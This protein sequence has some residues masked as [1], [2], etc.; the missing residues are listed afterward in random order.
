MTERR[1]A[2]SEPAP[3]VVGAA[4]DAER[5]PGAQPSARPG[6]ASAALPLRVAYV[7]MLFPAGSETFATTDVRVLRGA[8]VE[9]AVHS[10]RTADPDSERMLTQR[11]L[12]G[13][14]VTH[15]GVRASL[16]GVAALLARPRSALA[17]LGWLVRA[18]AR[19]PTHLARA[20]LVTPRAFGILADLQRA[21]PDVVHLFWGHYPALV[22][23]L[24]QRTMP[25]TVV[26]V[27]LGAH[28][29]RIGFGGSGPVACAAD[30]V[31]THVRANVPVLARL[32]VPAEEVQVAYRGVDVRRLREIAGVQRKLPQR[33]VT[34]GRLTPEKGVAEVLQAFALVHAQRPDASLVVLGDGPER[35]AL[36]RMAGDL[37]VAPAVR[38]L[39]H[40]DQDAVFTEM[41]KAGVFLFLSAVESLPNVV[42]EAMACS[43]VCVSSATNGLEELLVDGAY[44]FV[45]PQGDVAAAARAAL[46]VLEEPAASERMAQAAERHVAANFDV[47]RTMGRY[48]DTWRSLV[49]KRRAGRAEHAPSAGDVSD[50]G[51]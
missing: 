8:G 32:G 24:V 22:G 35:A 15:N 47:E 20:L 34:A 3:R 13:L 21:R 16:R 2:V 41:A 12:A 38:F 39:G 14:R 4:S 23:W 17:Y 9:V 46:R 27:F 42:K 43:C 45:V 19:R 51:R 1:E 5:G 48:A 11:G 10:L 6:D 31:W 18:T 44:G 29:L 26:S 37:G 25:E 50:P 33:I 36:E 7:T 28:D 49:A 40:V 30:V